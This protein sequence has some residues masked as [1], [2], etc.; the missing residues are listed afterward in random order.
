MVE[1]FSIQITYIWLQLSWNVQD[2]PAFVDFVLC[3][4]CT[5][6]LSYSYV[7]HAL[8]FEHELHAVSMQFISTKSSGS[9]RELLYC[10]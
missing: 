1:P 5:C 9:A 2:S 10:H 8:F 3:L 4:G 7:G 6:C